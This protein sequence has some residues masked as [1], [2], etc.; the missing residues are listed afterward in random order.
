[1]LVA[2]FLYNTHTISELSQRIQQIET[3]LGGPK[4]VAWNEKATVEK[5]RR[6]VVRIVGGESEGSGF[7]IKK[8]GYILTNFHVIEFEPSP[9]VVLPDNTFETAKVIM[10]DKNADLAVVKIEKDLLPLPLADL[11]KLDPTEELL[12]IGFPLGGDLPGESFVGKG[13]ISARRISKA[14]GIE[15]IETNMTLIRGMSG[16]PM[17]N[18]GGEVVGVSTAGLFMGGMG[19]GISADSV[20]EKWQEMAMSEDSLKDVQKFVF[21]P[22]KSPLEAV[23]SF[24]NYLK[25]RKLEKAFALLSDNF[26]KGY[27]FEH[28]A[29]GYEP[30]LDTTVIRIEPD[31]K[32]EGRINVK[33]ATKD[34]V[35]GEIVYKFFQGHWDI[36]KID[37]KWLLWHPRIKEVKSPENSWFLSAAPMTGPR[38]PY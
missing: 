19:I 15:Y 28:W 10:A 32:I 26:V 31:K 33:L 37:G 7:A 34:L 38:G 20:R 14:V 29:K 36:R 27:S 4:K 1:M 21:E 25:A 35:D 18:V 24:Y 11:K 30:L 13:S 6:S 12:A 8:G 5:V 22:E 16:G 9:K 23:R 17:V 2:A 3:K